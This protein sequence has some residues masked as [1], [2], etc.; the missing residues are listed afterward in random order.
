MASK[1]LW[2]TKLTANDATAKEELGITRVEWNSTDSCFKKYKYVRTA[3]DTTVANGTVL[4]HSDTLGHIASLDIDDF[5]ESTQILGVG[6]GVIT[7]TYYGW[8]QVGGYHPTV[9]T[10]GDDDI[11]NGDWIIYGAADGVCNSAAAGAE[12]EYNAFGYAVADDVNGDNTVAV[13]LTI[14][15]IGS[16]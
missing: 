15:P 6:I 8:V 3:S 4:G 2:A 10:N 13:M 5:V 16:N 14:S 11:S 7:A 12:S 1:H 9:L